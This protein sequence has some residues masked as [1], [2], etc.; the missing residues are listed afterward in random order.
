MDIVLA[1]PIA[2]ISLAL[3]PFIALA[4]KL[5]DGGPIFIVQERVGKD[6]PVQ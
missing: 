1:V 3:F 5:D 2:L 6:G 4:I